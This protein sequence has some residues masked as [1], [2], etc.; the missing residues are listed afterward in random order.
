ML[1]CGVT[2]SW[3]LLCFGVSI[4]EVSFRVIVFLI[5]ARVD[6]HRAIRWDLAV[7]LLKFG[8]VLSAD[9]MVIVL[10]YL[11]LDINDCR[12]NNQLI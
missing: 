2:D 10:V 11:I 12:R 6:D 1:Q 9:F 7:C 5:P 3:E 4:A 8:D